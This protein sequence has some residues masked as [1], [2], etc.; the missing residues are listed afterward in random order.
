LL[1]AFVVLRLR[2]EDEVALGLAAPEAPPEFTAEPQGSTE[3]LLEW[4]KVPNA[5]GYQVRPISASGEVG[6]ALGEGD[7]DAATFSFPVTDLEPSTEHC[8]AIV[9]VGPEGA[10]NSQATEPQCAT[11][12]APSQL[13]RP[14]DLEV[15]PV[16]GG[17][18]ELTWKYPPTEG[19][20]FQVLADGNVLPNQIVGTSGT[21][22]LAQGETESRPRIA[23]RAVRGEEVSDPSKSVRVVVEPL[24]VAVTSTVTTVAP[25]VAPTPGQTTVAPIPVPPVTPP[26]GTTTTPT[27]LA[28]TTPA[29]T[30]TIAPGAVQGVLQDVERTWAAVRV[31]P[32]VF[33]SS[34]GGL[35]VDAAKASLAGELGIDPSEVKAFFNR[36]T[37]AADRAG[38]AAFETSGERSDV[39]WLYLEAGSRIEA[40]ERCASVPGTCR[41]L[42]VEGAA[43]ASE[44]TGATVAVLNRLPAD[45]ALADVDATLL[46]R[47]EAL[48]RTSVFVLDGA[49]Y[50]GFSAS[51]LVIYAPTTPDELNA[52][53]ATI[54]PEPC[55]QL[56]VLVPSGS[57]G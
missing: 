39:G 15:N 52:V 1:A 34:E 14:T 19:V 51:E 17:T 49:A 37:V 21:I 33:A 57:G 45:T 42:L 8:F 41:A 16:G 55:P 18:F 5:V 22:E 20:E 2:G 43:A 44:R 50:Q 32:P 10:G 38:Q 48:G 47:R 7:L 6:A 25:T 40:R 11:T 36:D 30:T 31:N 23:V 27:T 53:C 3:I 26:G 28:P 46:A 24:P 13:R 9:A 35:G 12:A 4:S 29:P 56:I 54:A